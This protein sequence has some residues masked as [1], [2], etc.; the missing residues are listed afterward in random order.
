MFDLENFRDY[1]GGSSGQSYS[2]G[3]KRVESDLGVNIDSEYTKDKCKG[4]I[5]TVEEKKKDN[6][7]SSLERKYWSDRCSHL[8]K[9]V[10]F[11]ELMDNNNKEQFSKWIAKQPQKTNPSAVY[12]SLSCAALLCATV[13]SESAGG[14]GGN[15]VFSP[16]TMSTA[17][18]DGS[19]REIRS[20]VSC[21]A[22]SEWQDKRRTGSIREWSIWYGTTGCFTIFLR[23][24]LCGNSAS[25]S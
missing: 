12:S 21:Q 9:Y 13:H 22:K 17:M 14:S 1:V 6:R 10:E 7:L 20:M 16:C 25:I 2:S 18:P 15:T 4:L 24:I 3:L 11:K 19:D 5:N 8:R 23:N